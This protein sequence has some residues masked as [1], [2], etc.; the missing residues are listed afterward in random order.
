MIAKIF[1]FQNCSVATEDIR[2][3]QTG[4]IEGK[5]FVIIDN[6]TQDVYRCPMSTEICRKQAQELM[7]LGDLQ[8]VTNG[9]DAKAASHGRKR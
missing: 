4:E 3:P 9:H 5:A 7:G 6:D 1:T 2:N 8:V